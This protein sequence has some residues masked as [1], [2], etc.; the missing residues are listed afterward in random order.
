VSIFDDR[1]NEEIKLTAPTY[2]AKREELGERIEAYKIH[3]TFGGGMGGG[4]KS[5]YSKTLVETDTYFIIQDIL[6]G[7]NIKVFPNSIVSITEVYLLEVEFYSS[8][9]NLDSISVYD[10]SK[11]NN[12]DI[13]FLPYNGNGADH[14]IITTKRIET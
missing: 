10:V 4:S 3:M 12:K 9:N 2:G 13:I 1:L 11:Y 14:R 5:V 7:E 8:G 6:T